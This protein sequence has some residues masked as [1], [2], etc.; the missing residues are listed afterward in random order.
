MEKKSSKNTKAS[1]YIIYSNFL[2]DEGQKHVIG[3]IQ[4]YI[5]GLISV[6]KDDFDIVIVQKA[7]SN[8]YK[9][10]DGYSVF[11]YKV[12]YKYLG[13]EL[14]KKI[15]NLIKPPDY[16]IWATDRLSTKTKHKNT[17][18]IQHGITFDFIDYKNLK[19]QNWLKKSLCLS[20]LYRLFQQYN[21]VKY[22]LTTSKV[23]CVDYNFLN[24]VRTVLPRSLTDRAIVIPNFSKLPEKPRNLKP[25]NIKILF[26][27]RFVEYRGVY[28]LSEI[29]DY[30][31]LKY[32][33]IEF[34]IYGEGPLE[35]YLQEK[36]GKIKNVKISSYSANQA[37]DIQ[38]NYDI[39]LV[40]TYGSEGT[41]LS[42]LESMACGCIP[43]AS[44]VG[45]MT[46]IVIDGFNGFLVN[47]NSKDFID[48]IE[49][50]INN[51]AIISK[52]RENARK[53]IE[54][55]FSFSVWEEKWKKVINK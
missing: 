43:I 1:I 53:T 3:G 20:V 26:A 5:F 29:I 9:K 41:S 2:D 18:S 40:P 34:G 22:F 12:N 14:L 31:L 25:R 50:L 17:I 54:E 44:N 45:G 37:H 19:L 10:I 6:F 47:P 49:Y 13:K 52:I 32:S 15:E 16:I 23:V 11:G 38:L 8:F 42:L 28:V 51:P 39:S 55:G 30:V 21:A 24:W 48:K 33:H 36:F 27:R 46:N 4:Q 7:K 35:N